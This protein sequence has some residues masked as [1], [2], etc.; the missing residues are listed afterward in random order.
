MLAG[1]AQMLFVLLWPLAL[2]TTVK[3][4]QTARNSDGSLILL[5]DMESL[6]MR[7]MDAP[8]GST[9]VV[10]DSSQK[11]QEFAGFG[12][13]FTEAS[14]I[15]WKSLSRQDQVEVIR[16]YFSDPKEGGLGYSMGRVPINSCDFS[17]ASY[18]FDDIPGDVH[19]KHFDSS[20]AHDVASG[21]IPMIKAAQAAVATRGLHLRLLASPWSPPAWMKLPGPTGQRLMTGSAAPNGLDPKMQRPWAEY[22]SKWLTA[23]KEHGVH[24]WGVT[25]QN[26]PESHAGWESMLWTPGFMA[27]FVRDHLGPVL[28]KDHPGTKIL[29][30]DHNKDHVLQWALGLY[31]DSQAAQYFDGVAVHWY[32]GLNTDNLQAT[33]ELAPDKFILA[34]EAC[35]CVG[36][37]IFSAPNLAAWWTRAERLALD[38]LED[39]KY[40]TVGWIDWNL[41]VDTKG[42]PNHQLNLCDANLVADPNNT[43]GRGSLIKQASFYYMGH[44]SRYLRPGGRRVEVKQTVETVPPPLSPA[45]VKNGNALSFLPCKADSAVQRWTHAPHGGVVAHGTNEAPGSDGFR[46]GGECME[47]CISGECWFPKVQVWTCGVP[48]S[49]GCPETS[50]GVPPAECLHGGAGNQQW[51]VRGVPGGSQLISPT[52]GHC[53][54]AVANAPGWT[55]DLDAGVTGGRLS[56]HLLAHR[57]L[58]HQTGSLACTVTAAQL[59]DCLPPGTVNQ[60]FILE[61]STAQ[62]EAPSFHDGQVK[63]A[64]ATTGDPGRTFSI[65]GSAGSMADLCLQPQLEQLPKFD[66]V[67]FEQ[68]DGSVTL[69]AMNTNDYDVPVTIYDA[70][71]GRGVHHSLPPH[72]IHTYRWG[73]HI[74]TDASSANTGTTKATVAGVSEATATDATAPRGATTLGVQSDEGNLSTP[75]P[76]PWPLLL[77]AMLGMAALAASVVA[78]RRAGSAPRGVA[79]VDEDDEPMLRYHEISHGPRS[80]Y[81]LRPGARV[82]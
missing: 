37:V 10:V 33:H 17:P 74:A 47:R 57:H 75:K 3:W 48:N 59:L 63:A 36:N 44:F 45:D 18:T 23:Y 25:V 1:S 26:E 34:T 42:G 11:R 79:A 9:A 28:R 50:A 69:V 15:N 51:E 29:G 31:N 73:A 71:A 13:A 70:A 68:P 20:V 4:T 80:P 19:L 82:R 27:S 60:T 62:A 35:N 32:G 46:I 12:G 54:T 77:V 67:G 76:S 16:L 22:F 52:N 7:S 81:A 2:G 21:M 41:I 53:L 64:A 72:A 8:H 38:I 24:F 6:T 56:H 55:V 78:R 49:D 14:A 58:P 5:K 65:R 66:A 39:L 40:W 43:L 61:E 30:F